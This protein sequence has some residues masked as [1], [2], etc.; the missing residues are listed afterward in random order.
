MKHLIA[1]LVSAA[2]AAAA[3]APSS[4]LAQHPMAIMPDDAR[5]PDDMMPSGDKNPPPPAVK[6]RS[7]SPSPAAAAAPKHHDG[8]HGKY[9]PET[10]SRI[11][12]SDTIGPLRSISSFASLAR[13]F[14]STSSLLSDPSANTTVLAPL[15]SAMDGLARKPWESPADYRA[16]GPQAY[17]GSGGQDRANKNL[18]RFVEAHLVATSP[19][20]EGESARTLAGRHLWWE[21]RHGQRVLMPDGVAVDRVASRVSNGELV[22]PPPPAPGG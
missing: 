22:S 7:A 1:G 16:L 2:A 18:Q 15:N 21:D 20:A 8:S 19:W 13:L 11:S 17:D 9:E 4:P 6:F 5:R 10:Q 12:L 3:A 14:T